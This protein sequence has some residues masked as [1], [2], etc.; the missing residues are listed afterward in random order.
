V[1]LGRVGTA[2]AV[3]FPKLFYKRF[4]LNLLG[5]KL[6]LQPERI[7]HS[8]GQVHEASQ[9]MQ[10]NDFRIAEMLFELHEILIVH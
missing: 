10:I 8:I 4:D 9:H 7:R 2:E 3:P 5:R 1:L 6:H